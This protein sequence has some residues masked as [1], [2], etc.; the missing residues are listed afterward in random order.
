MV[1]Y[2]LDS[3]WYFCVDE[4]AHWKTIRGELFTGQF[5]VFRVRAHKHWRIRSLNFCFSLRTR[6][7]FVIT[8]FS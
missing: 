5:V 4:R 6:H 2:S 1:N 8:Y 7:Y 3:W